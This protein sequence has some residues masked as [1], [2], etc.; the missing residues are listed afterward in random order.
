MF[1]TLPSKTTLLSKLNGGY[2]LLFRDESLLPLN[3]SLPKT[4]TSNLGSS[5]SEYM[6]YTTF[7]YHLIYIFENVI[8][9]LH[10]P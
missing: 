6:N 2:M 9:K 10:F 4:I 7:E 8:S 1:A 5:I 3:D